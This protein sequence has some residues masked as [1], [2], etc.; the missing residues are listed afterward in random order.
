M[1]KVWI[2]ENYLESIHA[3]Y[4]KKESGGFQFSVQV[5]MHGFIRSAVKFTRF[6][7]SQIDGR[8]VENDSL[9]YQ[10]LGVVESFFYLV[11]GISPNGGC[12]VT[13]IARICSAWEKKTNFMTPFYGWG[14]TGL[15]ARATLRRQF[16]FYH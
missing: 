10:E 16:T 15:K 13:T 2:L 5:V 7:V 3:V 8:L 14:S 6:Q 11:D 12:K 4:V 1:G 9:R